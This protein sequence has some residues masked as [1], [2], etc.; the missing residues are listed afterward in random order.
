MSEGENKA[1]VRRLLDELRDGW[2]PAT[3]EKYFSPGY[4][5]HLTATSTPL[6]QRSSGSERL[7]SAWRSRMRRP[8]SRTSSPKGTVWRTD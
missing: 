5:R 6:T 8:R 3:I 4:R 7:G 1:L 2:H